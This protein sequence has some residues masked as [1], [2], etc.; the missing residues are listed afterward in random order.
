MNR[1]KL[2]INK[3]HGVCVCSTQEIVDGAHPREDLQSVVLLLTQVGNVGSVVTH[4]DAQ[5]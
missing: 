3:H 4:L 1:N 2:N 5:G